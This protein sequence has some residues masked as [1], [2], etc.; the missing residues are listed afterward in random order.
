VVVLVFRWR[1]KVGGKWL[2]ISKY[3][4]KKEGAVQGGGE[5]EIFCEFCLVENDFANTWLSF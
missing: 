4:S 5:G 2:K 3:S 1:L